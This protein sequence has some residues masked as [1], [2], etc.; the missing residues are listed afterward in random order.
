MTTA[1]LHW[2]VRALVFG[3][4]LALGVAAFGGSAQACTF[5]CTIQGPGGGIYPTDNGWVCEAGEWGG[6]DA[7]WEGCGE[8]GG[9]SGGGG[10]GDGGGGGGSYYPDL[11]ASVIS[12]QSVSV[13]QAYAFS[14]AITNTGVA[15]AGETSTRFQR[16]TDMMG[17][18]AYEIGTAA[19]GGLNA[20][21]SRNVSVNHTFSAPGNYYLRACADAGGAVTETNE[22]NNCGMW[23]HIVVSSPAPTVD[24][25]AVPASIASGASSLL[26][27]V[28]TNADVCTSSQFDTL[29]ATSGQVSVSPGETTLYTIICRKGGSGTTGTYRYSFSDLSDL[30]CPV[31]NDSNAYS[32]LPTCPSRTPEGGSCT[33]PC[34]VNLAP[35]T[36]SSVCIVETIVYECDFANGS[37]QQQAQ[38]SVTVSVTA[39]GTDLTA[40]S[41]AAPGAS[42]GATASVTAPIYNIGGTVAGAS[43]AYYELTAPSA[44]QN[45][46]GV[47]ALGA[48]GA[49]GSAN[50]SFNYTFSTSGNYQVRFCADWYGE[51]AETN[52]GNN[53]GPWT[54]IAIPETPVSNSV[55]CSVNTTSVTTGQSVTYTANP[56]GA[57][58]NPYTWTPSD[59]VGSYGSGST[60]SRSF[61]APG[62]YGMQV[63]ATNASSAANCPVVTVSA[64]FCASGN[65]DLTIAAT[66]NRVRA[67]QPST[68]TWSAT[69]IPGASAT[70][71]VSGPGV[72]WS[73]SVT[74]S[75][76]CSASG[77]AS[78]TINTQSTYTLT[79]GVYSESVTVNVIPNF[80]EF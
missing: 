30:T 20:N 56:V 4:L 35:N 69:G 8:G 44:K 65:A 38:D 75:P 42:R 71:S 1:S 50:A 33:G 3:T 40:G 29:G 52:E 59:G 58:T 18:G 24:L 61:A 5:T 63:A 53:C 64:G 57:A 46:S 60:A 70:C 36:G 55:S 32:A 39:S 66:P 79:C 19:T 45:A 48:I 26:S 14:T 13:G 9:D 22:G 49:A 25:N 28:A 68:I 47:V 67:G 7:Q 34:K 73:S 21:A 11:T 74:A 15:L 77:S 78:P 27:W 16:A 62:S 37:T 23:T 51:V 72:S 17:T 6:V 2:N 80:Q 41:A 43:R 54:D 10:G 31:T 12:P 76:Q